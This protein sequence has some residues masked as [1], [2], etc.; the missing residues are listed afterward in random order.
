MNRNEKRIMDNLFNTFMACDYEG[1]L[2]IEVSHDDNLI[3]LKLML[4]YHKELSDLMDLLPNFTQE[5]NC[6]DHKIIS[7]TGKII[8]IQFGK[9]DISY[10]P[11]DTKYIHKDTI[12]I[13][14]P[15]S[16]GSCYLDFEDGA[17]CHLLIG[18]ASRMGK[19]ETLLYMASTLYIQTKGNIEL[20]ITSTKSKDFYPLFDIPNVTVTRTPEEMLE[21]LEHIKEEYK[22]RN[23]LLYSPSLKMATDAKSVRKLYPNYFHHYKPIFLIIDEMARFS[24]NKEIQSAITELTET[25]GFVNVHIIIASQRPDART[26]L[27]PRIKANLMARICLSTADKNNSIVILDQEGAEKLGMKEGRAIYSDSTLNIIQIPHL[28]A[29]KAYEL[30]NEY[31]K[32]DNNESHTNKSTEGH[33]NPTLSN[34]IQDMFKESTSQIMLPSEHQPNQRMQS[35]NE[36]I[37][38]GW[39]RLASTTNK[40]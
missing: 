4:P 5:L 24:D 17:S 19:T 33:T 39:Y 1:T 20:Y 21:M 22:R 7:Q 27:N 29:T 32:E 11:F 16:F 26:V 2:I 40:G 13:E 15:S 12:K 23:E 28:K 31:R 10:L 8:T 37:N 18:G 35:D 6:L 34:K 38:N 30:L 9:H 3:E 14:L 36:T 25:A